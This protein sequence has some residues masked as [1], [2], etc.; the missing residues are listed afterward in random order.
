MASEKGPNYVLLDGDTEGTYCQLDFIENFEDT[1]KLYKG[2][3]LVGEWPANATFR[4]DANMK[5]QIKLSDH[6]V[7]PNN[8][9]VASKRLQDFIL[10]AQVPN[11]ELLPVKILD[12]KKRVAGKDYAIVHLVTTQDCINIAK[13]G[14]TW[15]N[16]N[17]EQ[18]LKMER[19][20][21]DEK[22]I[23]PKALVFRAKGLVN[24]IFVRRDFSTKLEQGKFTGLRFW[25]L[26]AY[27]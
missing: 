14:V 15:N 21:I 8:S 23:D 2:W 6:L 13:S 27:R 17:P 26:S 20:I 18:I 10:S 24:Q 25:E 9:I 5:K 4:M 1:Y 3:P 22:K 16:I 11:I 12:H 19:L 7:N